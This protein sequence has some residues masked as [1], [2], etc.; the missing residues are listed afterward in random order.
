M[1]HWEEFWS[2]KHQKPII[3]VPPQSL[4]GGTYIEPLASMGMSCFLEPVRDLF[5]EGVSIL[6]YGCGAGILANFISERLK[7][8]TYYGLEINSEH[9]IERLDIAKKYLTDD[10]NYFGLINEDLRSVL[11]NKIDCVVLISIFTHLKIDAVKDI[12]F[13]LKPLFETN[14]EAKIIF[15]CFIAEED[16]VHNYQPEISEGFYGVS[17]IRETDLVNCC[18]D[19]NLKLSKC[20]DFIAQGDHVHNIF[21]IEMGEVGNV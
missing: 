5:K 4:Y 12:I 6:D 20:S 10:R 11:K 7:D 16:T 8:Y 15:S 17:F 21:V 14:R 1:K 9:G 13:N 3:E 2:T 18:N 19:N